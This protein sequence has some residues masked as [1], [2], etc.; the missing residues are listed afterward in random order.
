MEHIARGVSATALVD[1]EGRFEVFT[2]PGR[3][4]PEGTYRVP[5]ITPPR[6][7]GD[8]AAA[9]KPD[10][11]PP[12]AAT[13]EIP[14]R[15]RSPQTSGLTSDVK[16]PETRLDI[17]VPTEWATAF[18]RRASR[19]LV[20]ERIEAEEP[21]TPTDIA[22]LGQIGV[23]VPRQQL[24]D[25]GARL[26]AT[27]I[28]LE[29]NEVWKGHDP[30]ATARADDR[31]GRLEPA[32]DHRRKATAVVHDLN[33]TERTSGI[34]DSAKRIRTV[35]LPNFDIKARH[36]QGLGNAA[37]EKFARHPGAQHTQPRASP[38]DRDYFAPNL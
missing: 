27:G 18:D 38:G 7:I 10:F 17:D 28:K 33:E 8:I 16:L 13:K 29:R 6:P 26:R 3:G 21:P 25:V 15:F 12:K 30:Q 1:T 19:R 5:L 24:H 14:A 32:V 22:D 20:D 23:G 35:R 2:A 36:A 37:A 9:L 4:V 11:K 34:H 31:V